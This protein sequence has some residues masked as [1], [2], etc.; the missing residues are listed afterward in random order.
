MWKF[1]F[2]SSSSSFFLFANAQLKNYA[3]YTNDLHT[4]RLLYF[5]RS[6]FSCSGKTK[7]LN[8]KWVSAPGRRLEVFPKFKVA[9]TYH[10]PRQNGFQNNNDNKNIRE[11]LL[12]KSI[13]MTIGVGGT[14]KH[15]TKTHFKSWWWSQRAKPPAV[16]DCM[17][18][19]VSS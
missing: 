2:C 10:R 5:Q 16:K 11:S 4:K 14:N 3:A 13:A 19:D 8:R 9:Q 1:R 15:P 17:A 18:E 7:S 12:V 6:S